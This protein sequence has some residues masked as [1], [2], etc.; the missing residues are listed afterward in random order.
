MGM[1]R[2]KALLLTSLLALPMISKSEV[3]QC[4]H[5]R[6]WCSRHFADRN[7]VLVCEASKVPI[8]SSNYDLVS[9][10]VT[11]EEGGEWF[12]GEAEGQIT[13]IEEIGYHRLTHFQT[14]YYRGITT[15][16]L[17]GDD[18]SVII[19][20]STTYVTTDG[21]AFIAH[22]KRGSCQSQH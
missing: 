12:F 18:V 6:T 3:I 20:H 10:T 21:F 11:F 5:E 19:G 17:A 9:R 16:F 4:Q 15:H 2:L 1:K 22:G 13:K 8:K 7:E 14:D